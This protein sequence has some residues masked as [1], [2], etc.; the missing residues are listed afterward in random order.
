MINLNALNQYR[1][2]SPAI[3]DLYGSYGDHQNGVFIIPSPIDQNPMR[4]IASSGLGWDHVSVSRY[5]RC[6]NWPEMDHIKRMFFHDDEVVMQLHVAVK[7]H[8]NDHPTCLH[9]WRPTRQEIPLP[10]P[11]LCGRRDDGRGTDDSC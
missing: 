6:P 1:D 3:L 7:D 5:K 10:P 9:L 2:R 4:I 8:V 11:D